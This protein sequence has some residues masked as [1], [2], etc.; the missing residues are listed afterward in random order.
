[1]S[2]RVA[3]ER[4][5]WPPRAAVQI[6]GRADDVEPEVALLADVGLARVQPDADPDDGTVRPVEP[7]RGRAGLPPPQRRR[8]ARGEREEEGVALRVDLH[9][10]RGERLAD[11]AAV[12]GERVAVE[13]SE[14]RRSAVESSMSVNANVTVPLGRS[15]MRAS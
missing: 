13:I 1:M 4:S 8:R 15:G 7:R 9:A 5:T 2:A 11:E 14:L 6:P 10:L 12:L 3:S